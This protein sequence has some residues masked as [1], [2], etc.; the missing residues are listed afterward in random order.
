MSQSI[1]SDGGKSTSTS[2]TAST[3]GL[4][5]EAIALETIKMTSKALG[6]GKWSLAVA[7]SFL[8]IISVDGAKKMFVKLTDSIIHYICNMTAQDW[9]QVGSTV[10]APVRLVGRGVMLQYRLLTNRRGRNAL[11]GVDGSKKEP[12]QIDVYHQSFTLQ[13]PENV[14]KAIWNLPNVTYT[15][16]IHKVQQQLSG[17]LQEE[18]WTDTMIHTNDFVLLI[19]STLQHTFVVS[20]SSSGSGQSKKLV[21]SKIISLPDES[22]LQETPE[23]IKQVSSAPDKYFQSAFR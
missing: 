9:A 8:F 18:I 13:V 14:W 5:D 6:A 3:T 23:M 11:E 19:N 15:H 10:L 4:L 22:G 20:S 16:T 12:L 7:G 17:S 2:T 1:T 21:T